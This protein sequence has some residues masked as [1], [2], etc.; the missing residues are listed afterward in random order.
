MAFASAHFLFDGSVT[1]VLPW[2]VLA[3]LIGS[4][5]RNPKEA[6]K[7]GAM[8]GFILSYGFLWFDQ[9][10]RTTFHDLLILFI[11]IPLPS[12]FGAFCGVCLSYVGYAVVRHRAE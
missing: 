3:L 10:G 11:I 1:N 9:T 2:G 5:A 8:Y 7:I 4:L 12:L 6:W